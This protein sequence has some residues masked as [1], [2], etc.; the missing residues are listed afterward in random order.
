VAGPAGLG[1]LTAENAARLLLRDQ[2]ARISG[3][4]DRKDALHDVAQ[5]TFTTLSTA[6]LPSPG[7]I[8][9]AL[10]GA[11]RGGHLS[12]ASF[13]P[14]GQRLFDEVGAGGRLPN[15]EGGDLASLRTTNLL[16]NKLDAHLQRAV[17]YRA[18][19]DPATHRVEATVT[20]ELRSDATA[21]LPDYV[22]ANAR[23]LPKGTDLL[24]VAWYS[25]LALDALDPLDAVL[26][27]S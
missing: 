9:A 17:R 26:G 25:G 21:S 19:V 1:P 2:Y 22:A 14:A 23:D 6:P 20:V 12:A 11:V 5:A 18:V 24:A 8:G 4:G 15:A 16:A 27:C 13:T 10:G 7:A 3:Y